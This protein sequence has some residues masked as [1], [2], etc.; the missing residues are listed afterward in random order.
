MKNMTLKLKKYTLLPNDKLPK[1]INDPEEL[2]A[3]IIKKT[4]VNKKVDNLKECLLWVP[5]AEKILKRYTK[6]NENLTYELQLRLANM[7]YYFKYNH[8]KAKKYFYKIYSMLKRTKGEEDRNTVRCLAHISSLLFAE[9]KYSEALKKYK[10]VY[11]IL[12]NKFGKNDKDTLVSKMNCAVTL[13]K[14]KQY[15]EALDYL[16]NP[17]VITSDS[18]I[19][20]LLCYDK[21]IM[22]APEFILTKKGSSAVQLIKIL[23][24]KNIPIIKKS[25]L[26]NGIKRDCKQ[27]FPIQ[28]KYYRAVAEIMANIFKIYNKRLVLRRGNV[29]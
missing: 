29:A 28:R 11:S 26:A 6:Y 16:I 5:L 21:K 15:D 17:F 1:N 3:K 22:E 24:G 10:I 7:F 9:K 13:I 20:L 25:P 8:D 23:E 2:I 18:G 27:Y 12:K 4:T 14:L 19:I